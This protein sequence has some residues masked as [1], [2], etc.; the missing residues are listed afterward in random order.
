MTLGYI[1]SGLETE[2]NQ[3][4]IEGVSK[5]CRDFSMD[6]LIF[7]SH[8]PL[9]TST[10]SFYYQKWAITNFINKNNI[11]AL[12]IPSGGLIHG[13]SKQE[14]DYLVEDFMEVP[15]VSIA[16]PIRDMTT[17][18]ANPTV[19][20]RNL[21][22]HLLEKHKCRKFAYLTV[23]S[24]SE[25]FQVRKSI[26]LDTLAYNGVKFDEKNLFYG[27]HLFGSIKASFE[28]IKNKSDIDFDCL[29]CATDEIA[30]GAIDYFTRLGVRIPEDLIVTGFDD[31]KRCSQNLLSLTTVNQNTSEQGYLAAKTAYEK[32]LGK[33]HPSVIEV[34]VI[35]KYRKSC[36]CLKHNDY[37]HNAM[38]VDYNYIPEEK[39]ES[40]SS[41]RDYFNFQDGLTK[42]Q[43]FLDDLQNS[44][45]LKSLIEKLEKGAVEIDIKQFA[46]CFFKEP[47]QTTPGYIFEK[48]SAAYVYYAQNSERDFK[49]T[50]D[51]FYFD[52]SR[53][54]LPAAYK[55]F[56]YGRNVVYLLYQGNIQY[57]Y[58][59]YGLGKKNF[60][61]Y[62]FLQ[63]VVSSTLIES[64]EYTKKELE[65]K[66]LDKK[67]LNLVSKN[68]S[69]MALSKIDELTGIL[70][71]RG[72]MLTAQQQLSIAVDVG[73]MGIVVY[74]DMDGLKYI[75]DTY[76][77]DAG[78]RAIIAEVELLK[79]TFRAADTF[80][81]LGGDEFAILSISVSLRT[82]EFLKEKLKDLCD[83]W[84]ATSNEPFKLSISLGAV[85]FSSEMYD[86]SELLK[87]AD[88]EQY[89][90][91]RKHKD[92]QRKQDEKN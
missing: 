47:I 56:F 73:K 35:P 84:N 22:T 60:S 59:I 67:N 13:I 54:L 31:T 34:Q 64:Y 82:F 23:H 39:F 9:P 86:L 8:Y 15:T 53:D 44:V 11:D 14:F 20:F 16:I 27:N 26:F 40:S 62:K 28:R 76:G 77:H 33:I 38:D 10:G 32:Y 80:G 92:G 5:F 29:V 4:L 37:V 46:I 7:A 49:I 30:F 42:I 74:G 79:K 87:M 52:C 90:E 71:R 69:L 50:E 63:Y 41:I 24:T 91:K 1:T 51:Y 43:Y 72:F 36:G 19:G 65:N 88:E 85:E 12:V 18:V 3:A 58:V 25:E 57:G 21:I 61:L 81:R 6:L 68:N 17:V 55:K 75:N 70:N 66:N 83:E 2:Y 45:S 78:D 89:K 48:P